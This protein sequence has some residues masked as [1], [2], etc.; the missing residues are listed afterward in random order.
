MSGTDV[1][2]AIRKMLAGRA[3]EEVIF[4]HACP[5][6]VDDLEKATIA[7][8]KFHTLYGYGRRGLVSINPEHARL[9]PEIMEAVQITLDHMYRDVLDFFYDRK[10]LLRRFATALL[11]QRYMD[12]DDVSNALKSPLF[13]RESDFGDPAVADVPWSP[14]RKVAA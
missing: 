1:L 10:A 11:K 2:T 6:S 4:G 14:E 3:A 12:G 7:A 8:I 13:K 9:D 5:G